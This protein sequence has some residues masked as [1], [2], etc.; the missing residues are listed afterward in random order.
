MGNVLISIKIMPTSVEINLEDVV[1][2]IKENVELK[3]Y[4]IE[5]MA[6]GLKCLRILVLTPD[7]GGTDE[8]EGLI[9]AIDGVESVEVENVTLS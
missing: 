2:K 9:N 4:K 1:T 7:K 6:F 3:D 5:P 8:I